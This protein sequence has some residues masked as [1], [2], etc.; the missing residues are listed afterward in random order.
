MRLRIKFILFVITLHVI[1]TVLAFALLSY[2]K[3]FFFGIQLLVI[4]S[5]II[6][7]RLY[8]YF[9]LP[10]EILAAG[11]ES[12]NNRD[13]NITI[14]PTGHNELDRLIIVYNKM[15]EQLR[16]ERLA[17]QEQQY[18]L[19]HLINAASIGVI[20]LD[21]DEMVSMISPAAESILGISREHAIGR[22]LCERLTPP[23]EVIDDLLP[24]KSVIVKVN[25]IR[26]Y[27][28]TKSSFLDRG[29]RRRFF[30]IEELTDE[31]IGIQRKAYEKVIRAMSHEVNNSV[32]A[33]NSIL[34]SLLSDKIGASQDED[35]DYG[36]TI[37]IAIE[38]NIHL[39]KF[40]SKY[41]DIVRIP[42]PVLS[43]RDIHDLLKSAYSLMQR[44]S[45]E[46][47]IEW[48]FDFTP[49]N[50]EVEM[51]IV[52]MEQAIINIL[53]NAMEAIGDN[54]EI[55]IRTSS[56]PKS[57]RII[58]TGG[59]LNGDILPNLF[60]PFFTTKKDGQGIGLTLIREILMNHG[61]AFSLRTNDDGKTQFEII[62]D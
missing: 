36:R 30:I 50:L 52:Q 58:D 2:S 47:N 38:R 18:F 6:S 5:A 3:Y 35:S 42:K 1:L 43:K 29:F 11:V 16:Q 39:S 4:I 27:R 61:F 14:R 53:R 15:I 7:F 48:K 37:K 20:I 51:D 40:M 17:Q 41:A 55:D 46:R 25:G 57:L 28:C 31:I 10:M 19:E 54:G 32:G 26:V 12:I 22:P 59:G 8:R 49:G 44:E 60:S 45:E 21:H 23:W 33:I 9:V 24:D 56:N 13:F 34:D 62:F